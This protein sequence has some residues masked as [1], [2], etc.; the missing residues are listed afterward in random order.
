MN[1]TQ[2]KAWVDYA[3]KHQAII[4]LDNAYA[5]FA[6]SPDVP[7]SIYEIEGADQVAVECRTFSKSAGF[8]GLRCAYAVV[9]KNLLQNLH[10]MWRRRHVT[11]FNGVAYPIQR[12]AEA[13]L[14]EG[15]AQAD[16]QVAT[17]LESGRILREA[18]QKLEQSFV[19]GVDAPYIWWKAPKGMT[20]WQFFDI[21]LEE[22]QILGIPGSGFGPGGEGY[23]RLTTFLTPDKAHEAANRLARIDAHALHTR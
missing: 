6:R 8:T 20:S 23:L 5:A 22:C 4:V 2:L 17:Y 15:K 11:K 14:K 16:A 7:N 10:A 9:P 19:G 13:A 21:I 3:L 12:G 18:L 1:R